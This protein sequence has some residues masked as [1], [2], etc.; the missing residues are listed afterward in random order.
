MVAH[1]MEQATASIVW[2]WFVIY[3]N[4]VVFLC[5]DGIPI[6]WIILFLS[7]VHLVLGWLD[8]HFIDGIYVPFYIPVVRL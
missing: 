5:D 1:A 6:D 7:S 8:S 3:I 2:G 4:N